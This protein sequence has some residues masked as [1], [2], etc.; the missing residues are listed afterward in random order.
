LHRDGPRVICFEQDEA[1][2]ARTRDALT[3][4]DLERM[5]TFAQL[6]LDEHGDGTPPCYVLTDEAAELLRRHS[7]ELV[8]VAG[9]TLDS[10]ASRLGTVDL[11]APFLRRDV[12]LLLD[13]ALYDAGLLEGQAWERRDEIVIHGI[14]PTTR[15][16]LEA[17]LRVGSAG[18]SHDQ[19]L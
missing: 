14:R 8:I 13:G 4:H 7:P 3:Q 11:V 1:W 5:V 16:L 10:G 2:V 15:G 17:T 18:R 12:T 9:P 6:P 19:P